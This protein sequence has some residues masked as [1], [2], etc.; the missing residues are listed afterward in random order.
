MSYYRQTSPFQVRRDFFTASTDGTVIE[1]IPGSS[2]EI[3]GYFDSSSV[4]DY[5]PNSE[6]F[7]PLGQQSANTATEM[8]PAE[9]G[10][11]DEDL[12][13]TP[14]TR[15][16]S[17]RLPPGSLSVT[18]PTIISGED[19]GY[20]HRSPRVSPR[21]S[22]RRGNTYNPTALRGPQ[23]L[24]LFS[25]EHGWTV[26]RA[27]TPPRPPPQSAESSLPPQYSDVF[28]DSED[29]PPPN[30]RPTQSRRLSFHALEALEETEF[31]DCGSGNSRGQ[32]SSGSVIGLETV[33]EED[34]DEDTETTVAEP[35][36]PPNPGLRASAESDPSPSYTASVHPSMSLASGPPIEDVQPLEQLSAASTLAPGPLEQTLGTTG[37][38]SDVPPESSHLCRV[39]ANPVLLPEYP[40][41]KASIR[42]PVLRCLNIGYPYEMKSSTS[43]M[44]RPMHHFH[45]SMA[46]KNQIPERYISAQNDRCGST[47]EGSFFSQ[48]SEDMGTS[49]GE[50][51]SDL[52]HKVQR[53]VKSHTPN[54]STPVTQPEFNPNLTGEDRRGLTRLLKVLS[55]K[56]LEKE[57]GCSPKS[58]T[59]KVKGSEEKFH[60]ETILPSI[61]K[62]EKGSAYRPHEELTIS[63]DSKSESNTFINSDLEMQ[64]YD[65]S[66]SAVLKPIWPPLPS[67]SSGP[68]RT[69]SPDIGAATPSSNDRKDWGMPHQGPGT[70]N[71]NSKHTTQAWGPSIPFP[72]VTQYSGKIT[73]KPPVKKLLT[74]APQLALKNTFEVTPE[75]SDYRP[76][77]PIPSG[78][79]NPVLYDWSCQSCGSLNSRTKTK[80]SRC[81]LTRATTALQI[82]QNE[83]VL[84]AEAAQDPLLPIAPDLETVESIQP[85]SE[86]SESNRTAPGSTE[87]QNDEPKVKS[88]RRKRKKKGKKKRN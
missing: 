4:D 47:S 79:N 32:D 66:K 61:C 21:G 48:K 76:A 23:P 81:P 45:T 78:D 58:P 26:P 16:S 8:D 88:K 27:V 74:A 13:N 82:L 22:P 3:L 31:P 52:G 44:E 59:K 25:L 10:I 68:T 53:M 2:A 55:G 29:P 65:K 70:T 64:Y 54:T 51:I 18:N 1:H 24:R 37:L 11:E 38:G 9:G 42:D 49:E 6:E 36:T 56:S 15:T 63:G 7:Q 69:P 71:P 34:E 41:H 73:Q 77:Q 17:N 39:Q 46:P 28:D 57:A 35:S 33:K 60:A 43:S 83:E 40:A 20:P 75:V 50:P 67:S 62:D 30:Q 12:F 5:N 14:L 85:Q 87:P 72:E 84:S 80:C 86:A 19:N